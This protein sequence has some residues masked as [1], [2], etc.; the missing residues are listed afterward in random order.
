MITNVKNFLLASPKKKMAVTAGS[1][2]VLSTMTG[3]ASYEWTKET[4]T[5]NLNGKEQ[6][7]RTHAK[8]VAEIL[9]NYDIPLH[10]ED[11]LYPSANTK[12]VDDLK[13]TWEASKPI[14]LVI[15][16]KEKKLRT[17]AKTIKD[18]LKAE[19]IEIHE[20]D[21][22]SPNLNE[23]IKANMKITIQKAF[24]VVLNDGGKEQHVWSTSTTV[25]DFLA[26]QHIKLNELDRIHPGLNETVKENTKIK[27]IRVE[28]VTDVVEEP[29]N[30][31]VVIKKDAQLSKGQQKVISQGEKGLVSKQY[32]VILENGKEV[33]RK[34]VK[35]EMIK[36]S[37]NRIVAVGTK[38]VPQPLVSRGREEFAQELYVTATAYTAYCGGCSGKTATGVNLRANPNAKVIAVDPRIIPLGT[39]VYVEGYGYAIAADTGS[40]VKGYKIDV[41]FPNKSKAFKWGIKRVKIKII[42]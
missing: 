1:F 38:V 11:Y 41:F 37:K 34:L 27:I 9:E 13:I 18:L 4:V 32:E 28:K 15:D 39:K 31:A 42:K 20:H 40:A 36:P 16:G 14:R 7:I 6:Q 3:Y 17:T 2:I 35:K 33:S 25:A 8:T 24:P 29:V 23:P 26:K 10:P 21:E 12:V 22:I 19:Q 30:Y 5:L